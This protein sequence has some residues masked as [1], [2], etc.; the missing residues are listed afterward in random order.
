M[1]LTPP[2]TS[3]WSTTTTEDCPICGGL[4][5]VRVVID[6]NENV[7]HCYCQLKK[8]EREQEKYLAKI[9]DIKYFPNAPTLETLK[10][11]QLGSAQDWARTQRIIKLAKEIAK[12]PYDHRWL[13]ILGPVG[14]GKTT[15]CKA[16]WN[17]C[18]PYSVYLGAGSLTTQIFKSFGERTTENLTKT[19]I[20]I[21]VLIIDDLGVEE[22]P[23]LT[24][25]NKITQ[26]I[27]G[28]YEYRAYRPTIIA[29]NLTP[30]QL[31]KKNLRITDRILDE[32]LADV[33]GVKSPSQR[34]R[35]IAWKEETTTVQRAS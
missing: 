19:L 13:T 6:G 21:P 32:D 29:S 15:I 27:D 4:T 9:F 17:S 12:A 14:T 31:K 24:I 35:N 16:L 28:R 20:D 34:T 2:T 26:I 7:I 1:Q 5:Y 8:W 10:L 30:R 23:S 25:K 3:T 33:I 18:R 11:V 22:N